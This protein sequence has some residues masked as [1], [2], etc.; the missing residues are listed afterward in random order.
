MQLVLVGLNIKGAPVEALER[1]SIHHSALALRLNE[2]LISADVQ[3]A[4]ILSTCNRLEFYATTNKPS[5]GIELMRRFLIQQ[6]DENLASWTEGLQGYLYDF[7]GDEAIR[8]L[9]RVVSGL[10]SLVVGETEI[11][12]QVARAYQMALSNGATDKVINVW[13]QRA[14]G[15]GKQVRTKVG[16][17]Q[18]HTSVGRIAVDLAEQELG[19]IKGKQ[20]LVLGAGEM[21]ELTMK[22]LRKRLDSTT[23][24]LVIVSNRSFAKAE[25]LALEHG[26]EACP[27]DV[28][29]DQLE[30]ADLVFSATTSRQYLVTAEQLTKIMET[31]QQQPIVFIDM[32]VPRDIDPKVA[33]LPGVRYFDIKQIRDVSEQNRSLRKQAAIEVNSFIEE[34]V[35]EFSTWLKV[36]EKR[37]SL[38]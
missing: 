7:V 16:I 19:D 6:G 9:Y 24:P 2:L 18:Y 35:E 13:F 8:H 26:F 36:L 4:V 15:V 3:G 10:D 12:G 29:D 28:L 32:A 33:S 23:A 34:K 20:I 38:P 27:L 31:R 22:H 37:G 17:D 11:L 14:L 21:S 30:Q 1:L 25:S 5:S